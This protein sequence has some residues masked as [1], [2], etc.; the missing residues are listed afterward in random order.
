MLL[1][2]LASLWKKE[3]WAG[4]PTPLGDFEPATST[5]PRNVVFS[6]SSSVVLLLSSPP[7]NGVV[8]AG[9]ATGTHA[10]ICARRVN[11]KRENNNDQLR[12]MPIVYSQ[13]VVVGARAFTGFLSLPLLRDHYRQIF[14]TFR[15]CVHRC[16]SLY[17]C[18]PV[19][20]IAD[21]RDYYKVR[22]LTSW[23]C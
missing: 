5:L 12:P 1:S 21:N 22:R 6:S 17:F 10:G 19:T 11:Q 16:Y 14:R 8:V 9:R 2:E 23:Y 18:C 7:N 15:C 4:I 20:I 3:P 13:G